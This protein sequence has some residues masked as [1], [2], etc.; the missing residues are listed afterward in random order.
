M[1]HI[2]SDN[3]VFGNRMPSKQK[4]VSVMDKRVKRGTVVGGIWGLINGIFYIFILWGMAFAETKWEY[5]F[6]QTPTIWKIIFLPM[7]LTHQLILLPV[8]ELSSAMPYS[9]SLQIVYL[10]LLFIA[11]L[12]PPLIGIGIGFLG[13]MVINR[14]KEVLKE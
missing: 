7:Y 13:I 14:V 1:N 5:V 12:M 2:K 8:L 10:I 3:S 4:L 9:P 11:I 6:T